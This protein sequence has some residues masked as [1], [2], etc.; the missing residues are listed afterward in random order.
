MRF[1]ATTLAD[2]L[3]LLMAL[4]IATLSIL[5]PESGRW[6]RVFPFLIPY[7]YY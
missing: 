1:T 3:V 7:H 2:G 6:E 5:L 4:K